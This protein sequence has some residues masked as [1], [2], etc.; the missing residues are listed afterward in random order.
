MSFEAIAWVRSTRLRDTRAEFQQKWLTVPTD[1]RALAH[2]AFE[3]LGFD[4]R[5]MTILDQDEATRAAER[6]AGTYDRMVP[7]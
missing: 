2:R 1:E 3:A 7:A 4:V 6:L 5:G